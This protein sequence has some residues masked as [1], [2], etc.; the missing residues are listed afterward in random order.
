MVKFLNMNVEVKESEDKKEWKEVFLVET[1]GIPNF[2]INIY[3]FG[4]K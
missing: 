2:N 4:G 1:D 3:Y